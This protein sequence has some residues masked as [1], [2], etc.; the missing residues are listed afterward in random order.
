MPTQES[1]PKLT[2]CSCS[3][4]YRSLPLRCTANQIAP[5]NPPWNHNAYPS[6]AQYQ[7]CTLAG[8]RPGSDLVVGADY[9]K[10]SFDYDVSDMWLN[11]GV[12]V[13]FFLGFVAASC[14]A[15][16][17]LNHGSFSSAIV[18]KKKATKE[19]QELDRRLQERRKARPG[20][21][22]ARYEAAAPL[23]LTSK[24]FTWR[25]LN[26]KIGRLQL[27]NKVDGYSEPGKLTALMG[28][29]GAGKTTL[30][31]VLA[32]RKSVGVITGERLI[33]G[34]PVDVSFQR[35]CGFAE[36]FGVDEPTATVREALRF[37]AYLRQPADV[38]IE[39]K[40]A[41][42]EE[43]I[44]VL[45]M[46]S[47]AN[48]VIG[49]PEWGLG[50]SDRK[51]LT[52]GV[53][54]ASKPAELL[55]LD[56]PTTG[57]DGQSAYNLVLHLRKLAAAGQS[58]V[59]TIHQPSSLLF[60]TFDRLLLLQRGGE[61]VYF[62]DIGRNSSEVVKYFAE[63]GAPMPATANPAEE[64]LE[65]IGA[66]SSRRVGRRDWADVY[67]DSDLYQRNLRRIDELNGQ[68]APGTGEGSVAREYAT[69]F[70]TQLKHT[71]IRASRSS[72]R[73]PDYQFT[74]LFQH[75]AIALTAGLFWL[76]LGNTGTDLQYR[77]FDLFV[78]TVLPALILAA[79][80]PMYLHA[81]SVFQRE[82]T[83]RT[84]S[85]QVFAL[86]QI[87]AE[88]PYCL[89]CA[90]VYWAINFF[91]TFYNPDVRDYSVSRG[92]YMFAM[93]LVEEV[94]ATT[95]GQFIGAVAPNMFI[96]SLTT[97]FLATWFAL[98]CGSAIPRAAMPAFYREFAI[99]ECAASSEQ[100]E[101]DD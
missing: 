22:T 6:V 68:Q 91:M 74:R 35:K 31:D 66:G 30:L 98:L 76:Q 100:R 12:L 21:A 56:E 65:I 8:A 29:S 25:N 85:P 77:I 90:I 62:G 41:Y 33:A 20:T 3:G 49:T 32:D 26:Y 93:L 79:I 92:G 43:L 71:L 36:Q 96:A 99:C 82:W 7:T 15:I 42:V 67:R 51:R 84:Y 2:C 94:F 39:E 63:H 53:E 17:V 57:L 23:T 52:I 24:P 75:A 86:S 55:F 16:E 59:C 44:S 89:A 97:P 46:E 78:L 87:I 95:L 13:A 10:A 80:E 83:S 40:N 19:E 72:W 61:V 54:L 38:P 37:S 5:R 14:V 48:A 34:S 69:P 4:E 27:L 18:V 28:A 9:L 1:D 64:M 47:I 50:L 58:I 60:E 101:Y 88:L 45:G 81:R 11:F 73:Q 70:W